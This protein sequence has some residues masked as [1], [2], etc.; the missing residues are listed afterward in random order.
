M[1]VVGAEVLHTADNCADWTGE[2]LAIGGVAEFFAFDSVLL[3]CE[4]EGD[5]GS[6][7][8][9]FDRHRHDVWVMTGAD[10]ELDV[11]KTER[12][13]SIAGGICVFPWSQ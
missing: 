3:V 10:L 9:C 7:K 4:G 12:G 13:F 8:Q 5:K 11:L 1:S 6:G 2:A